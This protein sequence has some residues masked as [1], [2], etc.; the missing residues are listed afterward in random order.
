MARGV[1]GSEPNFNKY[2]MLLKSFNYH[3]LEGFEQILGQALSL[4]FDSFLGGGLGKGNSFCK[5]IT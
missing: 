5:N 4:R 3:Q 2:G 1:A